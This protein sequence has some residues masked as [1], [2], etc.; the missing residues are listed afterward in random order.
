MD[1]E[2]LFWLVLV[3]VYL[4]QALTSKK[5]KQQQQ[6]QQLPNSESDLLIGQESEAPLDDALSEISKILQKTTTQDWPPL[7][8]ELPQ[9]EVSI[10]IPEVKKLKPLRSRRPVPPSKFYDEPFENKGLET[11]HA[12]EISRE[13]EAS[14]PQESTRPVYTLAG[15]VRKDTHS[16]NKLQEAIILADVLGPPKGKRRSS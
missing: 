5:K 15:I 11:F 2:L 4:L 12:P 7:P 14:K 16:H 13:P 10:K 6:Q 3:V 8:H 9:A 1:S